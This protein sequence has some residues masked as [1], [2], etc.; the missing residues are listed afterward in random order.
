MTEKEIQKGNKLIVEFMGWEF[1]SK[2]GFEYY[3]NNK[4]RKIPYWGEYS[5]KIPIE[6]FDYHL[7]WDWLIPVIKKINNF[8]LENSSYP[9]IK[10][11]LGCSRDSNKGHIAL[12]HN[13]DGAVEIISSFTIFDIKST[14]K[15]IIE[16]I[17]WYNKNY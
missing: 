13:Y 17:K 15:A 1:H 14:H 4:D 7:S 2:N 3:V 9:K 8:R 16:F 11:E 6:D 12:W 5:S 10:V